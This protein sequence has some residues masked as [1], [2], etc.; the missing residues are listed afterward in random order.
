MQD[1]IL[2]SRTRLYKGHHVC[3]YKFIV[4]QLSSRRE[5]LRTSEVSKYY[6]GKPHNEHNPSSHYL[7]LM[8]IY[9]LNSAMQCPNKFRHDCILR[10]SS[11]RQNLAVHL[12]NFPSDR[13]ICSMFLQASRGTSVSIHQTQHPIHYSAPQYGILLT[14]HSLQPI[15]HMDEKPMTKRA[16]ASKYTRAV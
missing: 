14:I 11:S 10:E 12:L 9:Y 15:Q 1:N 4:H 13:T 16:E 6:K 5:P 7:L 8:N 2:F 3:K